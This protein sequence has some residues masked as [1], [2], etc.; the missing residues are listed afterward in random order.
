MTLQRRDWS[1]GTW[2]T[3]PVS[4]SVDGGDLV[5]EAV[6][7]SD[8]WR[9][10]SYGFTRD[11]A[12]GLVSELGSSGAVEV[13]FT[14]DFTDQFD[15]AGVIVRI[16]ETTWIK[17]GVEYADGVPQVGAVVTRGVSDWSVAPVPEWSG[18]RIR[19][20]ASR[21]GDAVTVRAGV[22]GEELRLVRLAPFP[23][24][25]RAQAGPFLAA[26][27]RAGLTVR[28]HDWATDQADASLH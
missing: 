18:K 16:D 20:R 12:H 26:P 24:D 1:E 6:E 3:A 27:S 14:C 25:V 23:A 11:N 8:A 22:D 10:T 21:A 13:V 19:V 9:V 15:Q 4:A 17:A 7:G 28:F 5:V 2:T